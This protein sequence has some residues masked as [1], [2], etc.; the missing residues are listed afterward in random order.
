[1]VILRGV[2]VVLFAVWMLGSA[3]ANNHKDIYYRSFWSPQYQ[4]A[5]LD[6]C[7]VDH[8]SCGEKVAHKYCQLMGYK[9]SDH[10][11]IDHHIGL[12]RYFSSE[13]RCQG[14]QCSGFKLI[15]CVNQM[16]HQPVRAY[17]YRSEEFV[18]PRFDNYRIAWCYQQGQGCGHRAAQSF[19]RRMGY[20]KTTKFEREENVS[21]T[22]TIGDHYLCFGE[23]C[24]A[25]KKIVCYR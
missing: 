10:H 23:S 19:C 13:A 24:S 25:F 3:H 22:K 18:Y 14:W 2:F 21:A 16:K 5:R 17:S 7:T 15:H 4:G 8:K 12:T 11:I 1:M 20:L 6:Y 9:T